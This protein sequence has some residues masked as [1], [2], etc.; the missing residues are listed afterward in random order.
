M[1]YDGDVD[2]LSEQVTTLSGGLAPVAAFVVTADSVTIR[3]GPADWQIKAEVN[4]GDYDLIVL[5]ADPEDW[6]T[7]RIL[8]RLVGPLLGW[9]DRPVLIAKPSTA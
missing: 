2:E 8:G 6:W 4:E 7:R 9:V 5:A 3:Q 1:S